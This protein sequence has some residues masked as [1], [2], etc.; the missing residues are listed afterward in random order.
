METLEGLLEK[1]SSS[2]MREETLYLI[3]EIMLIMK[4][5]SSFLKKNPK[6]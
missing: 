6:R 5:G 1:L 3:E 2:D 4:S